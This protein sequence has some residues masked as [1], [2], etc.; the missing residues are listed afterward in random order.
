MSAFA[1][2]CARS[3]PRQTFTFRRGE[4]LAETQPEA[5]PEYGID[6]ELEKYGRIQE[7][8]ARRRRPPP[9]TPLPLD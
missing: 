8:S 7:M 3:D 6:D 9:C 1:N 5:E 2:A 4:Q